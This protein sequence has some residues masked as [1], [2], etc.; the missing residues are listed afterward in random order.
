[1]AD[2]AIHSPEGQQI[3]KGSKAT[4]DADGVH[5]CEAT[6]PR[7]MKVTRTAEAAHTCE[8]EKGSLG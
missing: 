6:E 1:M 2:E 7:E 4:K 3:T 8:G 5:T